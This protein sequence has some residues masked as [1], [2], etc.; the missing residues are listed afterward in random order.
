M[1]SVAWLYQG[2][3]KQSFESLALLQDM[4]SIVHE[5]YSILFDNYYVLTQ[6][7]HSRG[8]ENR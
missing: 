5:K 4:H 2:D 8:L 7:E 6:L 1:A 3:T